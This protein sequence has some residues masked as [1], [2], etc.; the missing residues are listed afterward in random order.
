MGLRGMVVRFAHV[1]MV[2]FFMGLRGMVVRFPPVSMTRLGGAE[3][4]CEWRLRPKAR[5][6]ARP[7]QENLV[8]VNWINDKIGFLQ[9]TCT[10]M[11][12]Y[13]C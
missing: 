8:R 5:S 11:L 2:Q 12:Y 6:K 13:T 9:S 3:W 1:S 7:F 4:R 10:N